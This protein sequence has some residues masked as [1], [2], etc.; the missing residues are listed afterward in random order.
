MVPAAYL[1]LFPAVA[2]LPLVRDDFRSRRIGSAWLLF[3]GLVVL[4]VSIAVFGW[5]TMFRHIAMNVLFLLFTGAF[6][7]GYFRLRGRRLR[8][9]IGNGDQLFLLAITPL[10]PIACFL[11]FLI[12]S[13]LFSLLWW[14]GTCRMR[15]C[16][17]PFVATSGIVLMAGVVFNLF[18][19][20]L[21]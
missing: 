17:V 21:Q 15:R 1:Y 20:W 13:C 5:V 9:S 2:V 16:T 8:Y 12:A 3:F 19:L 4:G 14:W 6:V 7:A 10:L 11:W 18:R